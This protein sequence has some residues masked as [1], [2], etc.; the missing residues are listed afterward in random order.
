MLAAIMADAAE[1]EGVMMVQA[2]A[3]MVVGGA[4][5]G[6]DLEIQEPQEDFDVYMP[7][8]KVSAM[9]VLP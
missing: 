1:D 8:L 5:A 3:E 9:G 6:R 4:M 2:S 7:S